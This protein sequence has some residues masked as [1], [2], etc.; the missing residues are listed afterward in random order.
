MTS[1]DIF[2]STIK[3]ALENPEFKNKKCISYFSNDYQ[4]T[5]LTFDEVNQRVNVLTSNLIRMGLKEGSRVGIL[6]R[7][8][9]EWLL[10]DFAL[11]KL[12]IVSYSFHAEGLK[13]NFSSLVDENDLQILFISQKD[14]EFFSRPKKYQCLIESLLIEDSNDLPQIRPINKLENT[15]SET[16]YVFTSGTSGKAK[17]IR[18]NLHNAMDDI[19]TLH[20]YLNLSDNENLLLFLPLSVLQQRIMVYS[21]VIFGGVL[22]IIDPK[23]LLIGLKKF[24]P[25]IFIAPP[26]FYESVHDKFRR[27]INS[28]PKLVSNFLS[29]LT[30]KNRADKESLWWKI[31]E[32]L[33]YKKIRNVFGG[34]IKVMLV[35]MAVT[36]S[37]T[38]KFFKD[39]NLP[40]YEAYGLSEVGVISLN[41]K[42]EEKIGSVGKPLIQDSVTLAKDGEII[43]NRQALWTTTYTN[44]PDEENKKSYLGNGTFATGDIGRFDSNGFLHIIGRKKAIL[45]LSSGY[46]VQPESIENRL[47]EIKDVNNVVAIGSGLPCV[48]VILSVSSKNLEI[49]NDIENAIE[50]YNEAVPERGK[51]KEIIYTTTQF[52]PDNKLLNPSLK[53]NRDNVLNH[54]KNEIESRVSKIELEFVV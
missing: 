39:V 2:F 29:F 40:L 46:K 49:I 26:L 30:E 42:S 19:H 44:I 21:M 53:I 16:M 6:A 43:I 18:V 7:N 13:S 22:S 38:L 47:R 15:S 37:S 24:K 50:K 17:C 31:C 27:A 5:H 51:I 4:M 11:I 25:T 28:K 48:M 52:S 3:K 41:R 36:K 33:L 34:K 35:G 9:L 1:K 23:D 20:K 45:A 14:S 54:F 12:K 10:L 32:V 8:S